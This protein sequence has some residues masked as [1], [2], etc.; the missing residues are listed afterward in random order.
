MPVIPPVPKATTIAAG[1][2]DDENQVRDRCNDETMDHPTASHDHPATTTT[3]DH[4]DSKL[5]RML[6]FMMQSLKELLISLSC[7]LLLKFIFGGLCGIR[8]FCLV[9]FCNFFLSCQSTTEQVVAGQWIPSLWQNF[10]T[11]V[12]ESSTMTLTT[13]EKGLSHHHHH[14]SY[15]YYRESSWPPPTLL[16]LGLFTIG[17]LIVHP[18]GYTWIV[19]HRIRYVCRR[20][21]FS[22]LCIEVF[23]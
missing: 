10:N 19:I 20:K 22:S 21:R 14:Y 13:I 3:L 15:Y 17:T 7:S 4:N 2:D 6:P 8:T 5:K 23:N 16:A 1:D 18:D 9:H 12:V 11:A